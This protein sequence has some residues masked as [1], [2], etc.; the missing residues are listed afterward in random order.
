MAN[1]ALA[2]GPFS[3]ENTAD[4][5]WS[6]GRRFDCEIS[7]SDGI[8]IF[9]FERA[10]VKCESHHGRPSCGCAIDRGWKET[11]KGYRNPEPGRL[12][13]LTSQPCAYP[14]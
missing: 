4:V 9:P 12:A 2:I 1:A 14:W 10:T 6:E 11:L 8:Y 7:S 13:L 5:P 3:H